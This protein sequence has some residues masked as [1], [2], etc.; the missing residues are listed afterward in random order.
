MRIKAVC[1]KREIG[2]KRIDLGKRR[3]QSVAV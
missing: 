2:V 1:A 3:V